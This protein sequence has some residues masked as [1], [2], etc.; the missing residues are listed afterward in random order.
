MTGSVEVVPVRL[1]RHFRASRRAAEPPGSPSGGSSQG[2]A[3]C[4]WQ[5]EAGT[6]HEPASHRTTGKEP[7]FSLIFDPLCK[8]GSDRLY[9]YP[10]CALSAWRVEGQ[11]GRIP[12]EAAYERAFCS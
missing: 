9:P 8:R 10:G 6:S 12:T 11:G 3:L 4:P 5:T 1:I 7:G 2:S